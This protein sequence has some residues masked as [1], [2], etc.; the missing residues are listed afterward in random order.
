M[1][2]RAELTAFLVAVIVGFSAAVS[3]AEEKIVVW[4]GSAN[5][6]PCSE[7]EWNNTGP[8]GTPSPTLR[9]A[10]QVIKASFYVTVKSPSD[11]E[12]ELEARARRCAAQA[13]VAAGI[14]VLVTS[15]AGAWEIA[16]AAFGQCIQ[17]DFDDDLDT[18]PILNWGLDTNTSCDW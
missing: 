16:S 15:G 11:I 14:T 3:Y 17:S 1:K 2:P 6:E 12:G 8:F 5:I 18:S 7:I 13:A 9:I 4:E 10:D